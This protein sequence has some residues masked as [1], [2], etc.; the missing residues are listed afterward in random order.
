MVRDKQAKKKPSRVAYEESHPTISFRLDKETHDRLKGHLSATSCS[1]ANCVKDA[2]GMEETMVEAR[3]SKLTSREIEQK[4]TPL[5]DLELYDLVL[6]LAKWNIILWMNLP[7]PPQVRCHD[8]FF[9]SALSRKE[10]K[11]VIMEMVEEGSGDLKCP[12]CGLRIKNPP[13]LAWVLL[14]SKVAE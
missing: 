6:D 7:D 10:G 2:L 9:P 5:L 11:A 4:R 8:C 13:Q 1:F 12:D 3:V 14:V